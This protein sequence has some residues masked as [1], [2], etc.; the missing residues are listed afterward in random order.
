LGPYR[1]E[2][3]PEILPLLEA[4]GPEAPALIDFI[5]SKDCPVSAALTDADKAQLL[6]IKQDAI[7]KPG[8]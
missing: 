5:L 7:K 8:G 6:R 4:A 3:R 2:G 1:S